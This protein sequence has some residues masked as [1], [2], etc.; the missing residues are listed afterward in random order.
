MWNNTQN[1]ARLRLRS[2]G[3]PIIER[4]TFMR[5]WFRRDSRPRARS[6]IRRLRVNSKLAHIVHSP[7]SFILVDDEAARLNSR[8]DGF[9][10]SEA[11]SQNVPRVVPKDAR[12]DGQARSWW[13][14][15]VVT[16]TGGVDNSILLLT[17]TEETCHFDP[18]R[19]TCR[20]L[21]RF[22]TCSALRTG[23]RSRSCGSNCAFTRNAGR[24]SFNT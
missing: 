3:A 5:T 8:R 14:P 11:N 18:T 15:N 24:P 16:A 9:R 4:K 17:T 22:T 10:V 7:L 21:R 12:R 6:V 20:D 1:S 23:S 2:D 13:S 19:T